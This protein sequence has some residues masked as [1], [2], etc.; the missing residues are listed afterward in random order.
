MASYTASSR[1]RDDDSKISFPLYIPLVV[2]DIMFTVV[3]SVLG[4]AVLDGKTPMSVEYFN[5]RTPTDG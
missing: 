2:E 1:L 4:R 5:N 3:I